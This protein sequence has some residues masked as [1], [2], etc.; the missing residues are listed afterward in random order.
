MKPDDDAAAIRDALIGLDEL[1]DAADGILARAADPASGL[2][3]EA[4]LAEL[5]ALLTG[6]TGMA[7]RAAAEAVLGRSTGGA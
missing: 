4:A 2:S 1:V 7:A 3:P 6:E 5:G